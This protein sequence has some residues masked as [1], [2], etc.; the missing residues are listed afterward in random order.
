MAQR[1][2]RPGV[3]ITG[4]DGTDME[5]HPRPVDIQAERPVGESYTGRDAQL[6]AAVKALFAELPAG[7]RR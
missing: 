4:A 7:V 3:R 5:L 2:G 6:E 1:C